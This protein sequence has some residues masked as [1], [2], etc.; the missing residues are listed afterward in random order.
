[1]SGLNH[2]HVVGIIERE[3]TKRGLDKPTILDAGC[4]D[5]GLLAHIAATVR[6]ELSGFDSADYGLQASVKIGSQ[7]V[8]KAEIR[9]TNPDGSWPFDNDQFDIVVSNQV[10]E[11]VVNLDTFCIENARVLKAGGFGLHVFPL[12]HILLEPHMRLPLVHRVRDHDVRAWLIARLSKLG[13]GIY[14]SQALGAGVSL[15][16]F[17]R[18]HADYARTFTTYRTWRQVCD[19][20]HRRGFRVSYRYT[21]VLAQRGA[22]RLV[23]K[24]M[25]GRLYPTPLEAAVFP[26]V[27]AVI[28]CTLLVEKNQEYQYT[29][30]S[31]N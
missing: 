23:G 12:R 3:M 13:L 18:A 26:L 1:M 30:K 20:F 5:G 10:L 15:G 24:E 28:S 7:A 27:R 17:A 29:W 14:R 8:D 25:P 6:S 9:T 2:R 22:S 4:G 21:S 11:H 16:T 31:A 19:E